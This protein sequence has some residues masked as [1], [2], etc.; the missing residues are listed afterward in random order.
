MLHGRGVNNKINQMHERSLY[1]LYKERTSSIKN[2]LK[3][4]NSFPV[5]H[6]NIQLLAIELFKVKENLSNTVMS[7]ILQTFANLV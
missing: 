4:N 7:N 3:K 2:L 6:R 5:L 1:I